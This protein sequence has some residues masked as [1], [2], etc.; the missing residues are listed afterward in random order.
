MMVRSQC[1][2]VVLAGLTA[3]SKQLRLPGTTRSGPTLIALIVFIILTAAGIALLATTFIL[4]L[5]A[6]PLAL[7]RLLAAGIPNRV[8]QHIENLNGCRWVVA[9]DHQLTTS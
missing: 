9:L 2:D 1:A 4:A 3:G 5:I 6:T 8:S 7:T